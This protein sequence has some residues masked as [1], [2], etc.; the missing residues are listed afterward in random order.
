MFL[1]NNLKILGDILSKINKVHC[2]TCLKLFIFHKR[3]PK[4]LVRCEFVQNMFIGQNSYLRTYGFFLNITFLVHRIQKW[5]CL[6]KTQNQARNFLSFIRLYIWEYFSP[7]KPIEYFPI[8][9]DSV[10][11]CFE[12]S[13]K[14]KL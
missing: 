4:I 14:I 3:W 11:T 2:I 13:K 10:K 6:T 1:C 12:W 8:A 7:S 5:I 9:Y